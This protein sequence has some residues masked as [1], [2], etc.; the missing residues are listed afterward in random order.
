MSLSARISTRNV[1]P[2]LHASSLTTHTCMYKQ[3]TTTYQL[4]S[5]VLLMSTGIT[6]SHAVCMQSPTCAAMYMQAP[7]ATYM[8]IYTYCFPDICNSLSLAVQ[9]DTGLQTT[10]LL[11]TLLI[12][13]IAG[14]ACRESVHLIG[15]F[16][17]V[18]N[19]LSV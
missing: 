3:I 7:L 10:A 5:I 4:A 14:R 13:R 17:P 6:P 18:V 9:A 2:H 19:N 11:H 12:S 1:T 15:S 8:H 16:A